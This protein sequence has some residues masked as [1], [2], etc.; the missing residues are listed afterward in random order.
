[1]NRLLC[2][3]YAP[4]LSS[5]CQVVAPADTSLSVPQA[6]VQQ[7]LIETPQA[8][9]AGERLEIVVHSAPE[10]SRTVLIAP[11]GM[12]QIPSAGSVLVAGLALKDVENSLRDSLSSEL[13]DPDVSVYR[14][15]AQPSECD[16][17]GLK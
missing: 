1:M 13:R 2:L 9:S 3:A 12:I 17:C 6:E 15:G 4:L 11:D 7:P 14:V 10:L 16:P 8:L 5:A